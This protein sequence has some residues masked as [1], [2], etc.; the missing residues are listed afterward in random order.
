MRTTSSL[1]SILL[2]LPE[3]KDFS[4]LKPL[5]SLIPEIRD[6]LWYLQVGEIE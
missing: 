4:K 3:V 1:I 2:I 5:I 6:E